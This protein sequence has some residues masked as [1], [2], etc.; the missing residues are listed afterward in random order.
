MQW[1]FS[2]LR[3]LLIFLGRATLSR[4]IKIAAYTGKLAH[5]VWASILILRHAYAIQQT[6]TQTLLLCSRCL[7]PV[8]L[9]AAPIGAM[10]SLESLQ[11]IRQFGVERLLGPLM[12]STMVREFAPG[13]AAVMVAMQGGSGIAAELAAMKARDELDAIETMGLDPHV[14]VV[15]PRVLGAFLTVPLLNVVS[16]TVGI[17]GGVVSA[18]LLGADHDAMI[19]TL[20]VAVV[21]ADLLLSQA[22]CAV[23]GVGIGAFSAMF[24]LHAPRGPAGVGGAANRAVVATVLFVLIINY[25]LDIMLFGPQGK[26][27]VIP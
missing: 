25:L 7:L 17:T 23:F 14:F 20:P 18:T 21:P 27:L 1:F 2:P 11:L 16:M 6:A 5:V 26:P 22:K 9:V 3:R 12:A 4:V 24:G 8:A 10:L 15:G 13:F 19:K